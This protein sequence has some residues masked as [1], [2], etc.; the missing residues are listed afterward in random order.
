M[1]LLCL[2]LLVAASAPCSA[3]NIA[4]T[5]D[6]CMSCHGEKGIPEAAGVPVIAG[7]PAADLARQ[8]RLFWAGERA[9]PQMAISK[10]LTDR[11]IEQLAAFVADQAAPR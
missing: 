9:N 3:Q 6:L 2:V 11:E 8:F 10:R 5:L 4:D 7:R 1:R